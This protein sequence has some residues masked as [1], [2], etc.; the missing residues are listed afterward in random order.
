MILKILAFFLTFVAGFEI[1]AAAYRW[2]ETKTAKSILS[3]VVVVSCADYEGTVLIHR[4]GTEDGVSTQQ[5]KPEDLEP[6]FNSLN[7]GDQKTNRVGT[8][9]I[10]CLEAMDPSNE[11]YEDSLPDAKRT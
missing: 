10:P 4:D 3:A 8:V 5:A 2:H 1:N 9:V 7:T 6:L 11:P